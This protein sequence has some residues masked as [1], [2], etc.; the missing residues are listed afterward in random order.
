MFI[1][2]ETPIWFSTARTD[3]LWLFMLMQTLMGWFTQIARRIASSD[4]AVWDSQF[5]ETADDLNAIDP[6]PVK[7]GCSSS[8]WFPGQKPSL[9]LSSGNQPYFVYDAQHVQGGTCDAETDINLVRVAMMDG[10]GGAY[11]FTCRC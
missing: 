11:L 9:V 3:H 4:Y 10:A 5:I 6:V 1:T 7:P 8:S 2:A